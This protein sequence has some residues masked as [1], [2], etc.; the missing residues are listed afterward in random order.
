MAKFAD[1]MRRGAEHMDRFEY[2]D[3]SRVYREAMSRAS[4]RP[5]LHA[6]AAEAAAAAELELGS[7][8]RAEP[9]LRQA[10]EEDPGGGFTKYLSLAQI[11]DLS[12]Q[13]IDLINH[14]IALMTRDLDAENEYNR[15]SLLMKEITAAHCSCVEMLL[16]LAEAMPQDAPRFDSMAEE[17]VLSSMASADEDAVEPYL[18][19][20]NLRLSQGRTEEAKQAMKSVEISLLLDPESVELDVRYAAGKQLLELDMHESG[21]KVL[22]TVVQE[23]DGHAE[24]WYVLVMAHLFCEEPE[25]AQEA[26]DR[27]L[28]CGQGAPSENDEGILRLRAEIDAMLALR[29][30]DAANNNDDDDNDADD[31]ARG[32]EQGGA[33]TTCNATLSESDSSDDSIEY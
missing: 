24:A 2:D 16:G 32:V 31:D 6:S 27:L 15:K 4:D 19:L 12:E 5:D 23:W 9:L 1:L 33:K 3:A 10:I 22:N 30:S 8:E 21:I 13:S 26:L 28:T 29:E 11:L 20:A 14:A 25:A 18:A 17:H 7:P